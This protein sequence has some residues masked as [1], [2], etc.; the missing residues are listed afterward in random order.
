[1][2]KIVRPYHLVTAD[3]LYH[4]PDHPRI[5]QEFVY[6]LYDLHP[7]YPSLMKFLVFWQRELDGKLHSVE[8]FSTSVVNGREIHFANFLKTLQ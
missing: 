6:Q 4:M 7:Q 3:I 2:L 5:L 1:M 8:V